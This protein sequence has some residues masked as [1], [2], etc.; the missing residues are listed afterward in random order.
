MRNI[1]K[2]IIARHYY[3]VRPAPFAEA[4][5]AVEAAEAVEATEGAVCASLFAIIQLK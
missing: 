4:T 5:Q 1:N 3:I 2:I